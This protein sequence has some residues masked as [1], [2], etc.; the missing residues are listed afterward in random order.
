MFVNSLFKDY[1]ENNGLKTWKNESTQDIICLEFNY[2]S[3][4]YE[5]E[6]SHLRNVINK[7]HQ[8]YLQ[9]VIHGDHYLIQS[10]YQKKKKLAALFHQAQHNRDRYEKHTTSEL[11]EKFYTD[12]VWVKY[13]KQDKYGNIHGYN[14]VHYRM[15]YR[16]TGKAKKGSCMFICD[17]LYKKALN[18][19]RMGI[20]LDDSNP[21]IVEISAYSP[22]ISSGI[23]DRVQINPK[24]ILVLKDIKRSFITNVVS[25]ETNDKGQCIAKDIENYTLENVLF[26]GEAL[27]DSSIFPSDANGYILLRQHF[28]KMAAFCTHIQKFFKDYFKEDYETATVKDMFGNIHFVKDIQVITT[29]N[30]M[31]WIKFGKTYEYWCKWVKKDQ[32]RFGIV[33]TAHQSKL[34]HFQKMSYQMVNSLDIE[35]IDDVVYES[36]NYINSLKTDL[37]TFLDYLKKNSNF[38]NDYDVLLAL[39]EQNP[40]FE[41]S[42]YFRDR[43]KEIIRSYVWNFKSGRVIQNAENLTIVGSPYAFLLYAA[44]G[45]E[46]SV[47][48]DTTFF[49]EKDTIQCYTA[50]FKNNE[51]LAFF[52]S[53]FNGKN[54]LTYLHNHYDDRFEKYFNFGQQ[55]IAV[56]MI[57]TDFQDRNNGS[58]QDSDFGY[59]TNHPA[60]VEHAKQCYKSY[61]TIVNRIPKSSKRYSNSLK[62]FAEVDNELAK[63]QL[64]IGE[65]SNLAQIAQT[66]DCT[67][68]EKKYADYVCIL[69]VLAQV[70]IDS[71]KRQFD[72]DLINEIKRIKKDLDIGEKKYPNFWNVIK[73]QFNQRNINT[74]LKCPMNKLCD[75]DISKYRGPDN[76]LGMD[77]FFIKHSLNKNRGTC[78][79]IEIMIQQFALKI[80][81]YNTQ[82]EDNEEYLLLRSDFEQLVRYIQRSQI[83]KKYAGLMS[84]LLD[85]AFLITPNVSRNQMLSTHLSKNKSLL[86]KIL[87]EVNP[88][89][90]LSCF[91]KSQK[92]H[93]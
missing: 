41:R 38:S 35:T 68:K 62:S 54:N 10:L 40:E 18:Y 23:V 74:E 24:N 79:R 17:R 78:R 8:S 90:L 39:L 86:L 31:K 33:K 72:V 43:R 76:T 46:K 12:G 89:A 69:S 59:T 87:Y 22:L 66:Y 67:Y 4:S 45:K 9:A 5:D 80:K 20:K 47:D 63:S 88:K 3:R 60:I 64:A 61:P 56:N 48:N 70:A 42:K 53:P 28:C 85:R 36:K 16:S 55:V 6:I 13:S 34:G 14:S 51:Y 15:L 7:T 91:K 49:V 25:V 92:S 37:D 2:G 75:I 52:R 44:T 71:A 73:K 30:A 21:M 26:D 83:S 81:D 50:R 82:V 84:W 11:R 57:G 1:L 93:F 19:L 77:V 65:S 32:C 58:D 27:I 29:D